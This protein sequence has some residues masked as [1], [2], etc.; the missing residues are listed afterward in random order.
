MF[1]QL[2][3]QFL[4]TAMFVV[5]IVGLSAVIFLIPLLG[6]AHFIRSIVRWTNR[7]DDP[8]HAK[9]PPDTP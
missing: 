9:L 2:L 1:Q 6:G 4:Y 8:R 3:E 7:R 5:G